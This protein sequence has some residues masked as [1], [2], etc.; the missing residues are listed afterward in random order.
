MGDHRSSAANIRLGCQ[1]NAWPIDPNSPETLFASLR[2]IRQLGFHGFETGFRNVIPMVGQR[3]R[4]SSEHQGLN[5]FG[6]HI[7]LQEYDGTTLLAPINLALRV[8]DLS[9]TLGAERLILS[10]APAPAARRVESAQ[11][12]AAAL[13]EI[14]SRIQSFGV[15]L[16]YH[17]HGQELE[18]PQPEI[19]TLLSD[20]DPA[21]VGFLLDA[22]H[23]FRAG[24]DTPA[25]VARHSDRLIGIHLRDFKGAHQVPLGRGDFPLEQVATVLKD[26]NWSGWVLAEEEREDASKPGLSAIGPARRALKQAF[27]I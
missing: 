1:T 25:F 16:A 13:N 21:L 10:G 23:A 15:K 7:F 24:I 22:G 5:F 19:E 11:R 12:K 3:V 18:G 26:K 8:A 4:L 6:V 2:E 17:N 27:G 9:N 20:T 14:A